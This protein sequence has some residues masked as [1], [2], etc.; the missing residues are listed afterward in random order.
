MPIVS[1]PVVKSRDLTAEVL[2]TGH[3]VL[4]RIRVRDQGLMLE[5]QDVSP[6]IAALLK[7]QLEIPI[8]EERV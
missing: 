7:V 4:V 8:K 3:N 1:R 2:Y 5:P 6:L